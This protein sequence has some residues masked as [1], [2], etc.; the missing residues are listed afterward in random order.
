MKKIQKSVIKSKMADSSQN[1]LNNDK[2]VY[3]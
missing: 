3:E 2:D 1:L